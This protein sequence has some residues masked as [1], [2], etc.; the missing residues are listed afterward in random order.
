MFFLW[1]Y[2]EQNMAYNEDEREQSNKKV[3]I[4]TLKKKK[5]L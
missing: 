5:S 4:F 3:R 2:T 1:I